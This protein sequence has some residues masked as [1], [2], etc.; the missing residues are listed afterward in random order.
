MFELWILKKKQIVLPHEKKF[1]FQRTTTVHS[2]LKTKSM[3]RSTRPTK[4]KEMRKR[5]YS[6][7]E[8][9]EWVKK[10]EQPA[11]KRARDDE[12]EKIRNVQDE[13]YRRSVEADQLK[14]TIQK[15]K[16]LVENC[17]LQQDE[18]LGWEAATAF[19]RLEEVIRKEQY[20]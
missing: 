8:A 14:A 16:E 6:L 2:F 3:R 13:E 4:D 15:F 17:F 7:D 5:G 1:F 10:K 9:G 19:Q 18:M 11:R 12:R 20:S